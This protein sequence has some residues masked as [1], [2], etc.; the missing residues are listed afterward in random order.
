M[1]ARFVPLIL[2]ATLLAPANAKDKKK[3]TLPEYVLR[4]TTVLV[5]VNPEAGEPL[6]QP[7]ANA[8]ARENVEKALMEW[9]RFRL[10]MDGAESDLVIAVRTG[11]GKMVQPVIKGGPIDSR[12]GMGQSTDS[13]IRIG[14]QQGHPPP[15]NDPGMGGPQDGHA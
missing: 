14:A 9:G 5:V 13:S 1:T 11:S 3:Q 4:A 15:L 6:E 12:P 10:V 2:L 7:M 8:T